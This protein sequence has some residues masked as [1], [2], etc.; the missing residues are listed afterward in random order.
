MA[1]VKPGVPASTTAGL[2]IE[3][4]LQPI[5]LSSVLVPAFVKLRL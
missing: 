1:I 2:A 3:R 4:L 5:L